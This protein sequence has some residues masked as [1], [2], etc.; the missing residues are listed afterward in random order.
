MPGRVDL[1]LGGQIFHES[2]IVQAE[3]S[4]KT[5]LVLLPLGYQ[6][7]LVGGYFGAPCGET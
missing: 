6:L 2:Y 7:L 1:H 4:A 3:G 5:L